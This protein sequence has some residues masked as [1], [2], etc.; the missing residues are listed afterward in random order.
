[1]EQ[2]HSRLTEEAVVVVVAKPHSTRADE[3]TYVR[4]RGGAL[5]AVVTCIRARACRWRGRGS[6]N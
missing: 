4:P 1:M 5:M 6:E 2:H 3:L